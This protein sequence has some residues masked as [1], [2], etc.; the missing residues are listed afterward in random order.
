MMNS[1][2][3]ETSDADIALF[4]VAEDGVAKDGVAEDEVAEEEADNNKSKPDEV[5]ATSLPFDDS[6]ILLSIISLATS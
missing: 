1:S 2:T 5:D 4:G 3:K 6:M